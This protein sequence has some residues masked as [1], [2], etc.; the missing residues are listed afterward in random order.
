MRCSLKNTYLQCLR[1]KIER[2]PHIPLNR[3]NG[4][5]EKG[6]LSVLQLNIPIHYSGLEASL[7]ASLK[8]LPLVTLLECG[9]VMIMFLIAALGFLS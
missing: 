8:I 5:I 9:K 2:A 3:R 1:Y 6:K 7:E 4:T